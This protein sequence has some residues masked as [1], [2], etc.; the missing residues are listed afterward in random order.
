M[1]IPDQ[2]LPQILIALE[3]YAAYMHATNRDPRPYS[4]IAEQLRQPGG[5]SKSK[6]ARR[7]EKISADDS[8]TYRIRMKL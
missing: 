1:T 8:V 6:A 5:K 2:L 3:Q 4:A 7:S